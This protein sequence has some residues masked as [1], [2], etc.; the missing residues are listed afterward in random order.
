MMIVA[1]GEATRLGPLAAQMNKALVS[2][3]QRPMI[4]HLM[5]R[6][7][8]ANVDRVTI[9][10]S[11]ESQSQVSKVLNRMGAELP[12]IITVQPSARGPVDAIQYGLA[13]LDRGK[14]GD[15]D[16]V[17]ITFADS[18]FD[19][20]PA[21]TEEP[22]WVGAHTV[23][24]GD[25]SWCYLDEFTHRW[26]DG[27]PT[28]RTTAFIGV[29]QAS[30]KALRSVVSRTI[31]KHGNNAGMAPVINELDVREVLFPHWHDVGDIAALAAARRASFTCRSKH[32][33]RL[34][35][36]GV[37][38][39]TGV[40]PAEIAAATRMEAM[41]L[42]PRL[43]P[44][45]RDVL[46]QEFIDLPS[47]AE[48][49]LYW[50]GRPD[51]WK[52]IVSVITNRLESTL[53]IGCTPKY[54]EQ[55]NADDQAMID[56]AVNMYITKPNER[57]AQ[58]GLPPMSDAFTDYLANEV[59]PTTMRA[60]IHGDLNFGNILYSLGTDTFKLVDARGDWG[61]LTTVGDVRYELAKLRYSYRDGF[62]AITHGLTVKRQEE[63]AA[64]D[65][66]I[67]HHAL[68]HMKRIAAI[69]ATLFYS[70]IPLHLLSEREAL[71]RAGQRLEKEVIG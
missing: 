37:L 46:A 41:L 44:A 17:I 59:V 47:L 25:R 45:P 36:R 29:L 13:V 32:A 35:D 62:S 53:W 2:V 10:T 5:A 40:T 23:S 4:A 64:M 57:L 11:P 9:V 38:T 34:D 67:A 28:L 56:A 6:A 27:I 39:K 51:M 65:E 66:V 16:Q 18:Y 3:Q 42:G 33:L 60:P 49:Y 61:G 8:E 68:G 70:A 30:V 71:L 58:V 12:W 26:V 1:G 31:Y 15:D 48:L 14:M 22:N 54:R 43:V 20:M 7:T 19:K 52:H 21:G 24:S 69:E 55:Q 63:A 50:P